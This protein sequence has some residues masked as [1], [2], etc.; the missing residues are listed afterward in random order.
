MVEMGYPDDDSCPKC[1]LGSDD[2]LPHYV[3]PVE[4]DSCDCIWDP[5]KNDVCP[6]CWSWEKFVEMNPDQKMEMKALIDGEA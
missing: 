5:G 3:C 2:G 4:C 6:G 1:G